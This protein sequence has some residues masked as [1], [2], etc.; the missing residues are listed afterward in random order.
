MRML[1]EISGVPNPEE[2]TAWLARGSGDLGH[3]VIS[4]RCA[5]QGN[6]FALC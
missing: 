1:N 6:H 2:N 5:Q 4:L 3:G